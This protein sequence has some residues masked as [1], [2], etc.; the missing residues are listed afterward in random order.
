MRITGIALTTAC[1]VFP[2][3]AI[4]AQIA[5]SSVTFPEGAPLVL[6]TA[7]DLT[8]KKS[9]KG[10]RVELLVSEDVCV[11]GVLAIPRG[12]EDVGT[13]SMAQDTGFFG[14]SGKLLIEPLY[15][16][17]GNEVLRLTGNYAKQ[18]TITAPG[19]VGLVILSP[20]ITGRSARIPSGATI[21]A[22]VLFEKT[23]MLTPSMP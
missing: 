9:A 8:S 15:V 14:Q 23:I 16:K 19:A 17:V 18:G 22:T 7:N 11:D 20:G 2:A 21:P 10:E 12:S 4:G 6:M 1:L 3:V 13:I 5:S